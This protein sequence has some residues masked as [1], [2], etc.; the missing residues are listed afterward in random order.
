VYKKKGLY[1]YSLPDANNDG[2]SDV[3]DWFVAFRNMVYLNLK[4][5]YEL[6]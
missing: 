5:V 6:I 4:L 1:P 2:K 3:N